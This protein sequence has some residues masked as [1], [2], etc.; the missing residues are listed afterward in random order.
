MLITANRIGF[1]LS[2]GGTETFRVFNP[3]TQM[4][5]PGDFAVAT[6]D[7]VNRAAE[8]AGK[9]WKVYRKFSGRQ[10]AVFL[11]AIAAE[12]EAL[13]E[14][15]VQRAMEETALPQGR[16][17]GERGRTCGQLRLFADL[18]EEGSWVNAIID[19]ALPDRKPLPRVDIRNMLQSTGPVVV[20]TASNFPL[21]FSTAG[22]DTAAALAAGC[23]VIV[24]AHSSH[25]GTNA[26]VSE[27]ILKAAREAGLPDGIFSSIQDSGIRAGTELVQHPLVKSVAFTGSLKGGMALFKAAQQREEPIPVFAEMGSVNPLFLLPEKLKAD[28][29]ALAVQIAES[30]NLGA[31]QFCTNPGVVVVMDGPEADA[32]TAALKNAFAQLIPAVMLN[33]G[34]YENYQ[35]ARAHCFDVAETD[36]AYVQPVKEG[37]LWEAYPALA[38]TSGANFLA[39]PDLQE[40]VFGPFTLLV[41][42]GDKEELLRVAESFKG[43]L[44]ATIFG[45][46][47]ELIFWKEL[48]G[49]LEEKVGRLIFNGVPTGV[50]VGHAMQHG[51]PFPAATDS[52]FTSVGSAAIKRFAR[53]VAYQNFPD[54]SLPPELQESNPLGIPRFVNGKWVLP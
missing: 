7:E 39:Q 16:I 28:P 43:Q 52:R 10:K 29:Q 53:P 23:P 21:A 18:V 30:V 14:V 31:G 20:F 44:T 25:A 45:L 2:R 15:L 24:K 36:I 42:C 26:L 34:I 11:R 13:G 37:E 49:A 8:K 19:P 41:R 3:R 48:S 6:S 17:E 9:A 12:I 46:D 4:E 27:A 1:E 54:A 22:G 32:F 40:E 33:R 38:S 50:E 35:R 47:H 51:G 5:L